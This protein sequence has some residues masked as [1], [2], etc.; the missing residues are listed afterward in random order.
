MQT[1]TWKNVELPLLRAVRAGE[2]AGAEMFTTH[3]AAEA[4]GVDY[5]LAKRTM[6]A[7][8]DD[9]FVTYDDDG[10]LADG[11][12]FYLGLRLTGSGR[13]AVGQWPAEGAE[14]VE[15]FLARIEQAI[16]ASDDDEERSRLARFLDASRAFA[17]D[18][19]VEVT[20][21]VLTGRL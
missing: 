6:R 17:R 12:G 13:R 8:V 19:S 18:V 16:E 21:A 11:P 2:E 3:D 14:I 5:E 1:P 9:G 10:A 7:L 20:S 4:S 15:A